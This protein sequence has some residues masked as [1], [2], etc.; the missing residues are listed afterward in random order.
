[1]EWYLSGFRRYREFVR[2]RARRTE[3]WT[4]QLVQGLLIAL[5]TLLGYLALDEFLGVLNSAAT[6]PAALSPSAILKLGVFNIVCAVI[7]I[8]GTATILPS[9]GVMAR[10]L[11][12]TGRSGWWMLLGLVPIIG[13]LMLLLMLCEDSEPTENRFG[14]NP[15]AHPATAERRHVIAMREGVD[16]TVG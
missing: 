1:M 9:I 2:G 13:G 8:G 7:Y 15:K 12:D 6:D 14:L 5:T 3:F 11:H 16:L 4:F 10:R